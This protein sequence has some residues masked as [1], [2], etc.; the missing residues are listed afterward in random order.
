MVLYHWEVPALVLS[1]ALDATYS[2][3]TAG[4]VQGSAIRPVIYQG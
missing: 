3:K 4:Y 1:L 2:N